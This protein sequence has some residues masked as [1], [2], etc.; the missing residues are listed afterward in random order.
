MSLLRHQH[1]GCSKFDRKARVSRNFWSRNP[2]VFV[3]IKTTANWRHEKSPNIKIPTFT[4]GPKNCPN[5]S[6][7]YSLLFKKVGVLVRKVT[8][9]IK[10][11][12]FLIMRLIGSTQ[13]HHSNRSGFESWLWNLIQ[14]E[15]TANGE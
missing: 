4:Q 15:T 8:S 14:Q 2:I 1:D 7:E 10:Y 13:C 11:L 12:V 3:D 9:P 6:M 5:N